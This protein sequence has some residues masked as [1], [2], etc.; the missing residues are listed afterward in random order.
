MTA[1]PPFLLNPLTLTFARPSRSGVPVGAPRRGIFIASEFRSLPLFRLLFQLETRTERQQQY[2]RS[3]AFLCRAYGEPC[4]EPGKTY[5]S[6]FT[7][8]DFSSRTSLVYIYII[9]FLPTIHP[10]LSREIFSIYC[11]LAARLLP[12]IQALFVAF[13]CTD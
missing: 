1:G 10:F 11:S 3:S 8:P 9:H 7:H 4:C 6:T 5:C 13:S 12:S 2:S